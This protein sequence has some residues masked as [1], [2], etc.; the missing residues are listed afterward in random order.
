MALQSPDG[1]SKMRRPYLYMSH[2][3]GVLGPWNATQSD[4]L[5]EDWEVVDG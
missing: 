4:M 2:A 3:D 1:L 5:A